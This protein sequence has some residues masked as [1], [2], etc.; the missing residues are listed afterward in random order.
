MAVVALV[1][2]QLL[3]HQVLSVPRLILEDS[4][5]HSRLPR[6][7]VEHQLDLHH[8]LAVPRLRRTVG[9][10]QLIKDRH[11][12][13]WRNLEP[14][15][16]V[17][18]RSVLWRSKIKEGLAAG[19]DPVV[20]VIIVIVVDL[21]EVGVVDSARDPSVGLDLVVP[22]GVGPDSEDLDSNNRNRVRVSSNPMRLLGVELSLVNLYNYIHLLCT[23]QDFASTSPSS[24]RRFRVAIV[25]PFGNAG[26]CG[27]VPIVHKYLLVAQVARSYEG[28]TR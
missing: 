17:D 14:D 1:A 19:L 26:C 21:E 2:H 13:M 3:V 7:S 28:E 4:D 27:I 16:A 10:V 6:C 23:K 25:V 20:T 11:S 22:P 8:Y 9:S 12:V 24:L 15:L 5:P 18:L